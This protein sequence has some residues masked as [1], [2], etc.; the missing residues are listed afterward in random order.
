MSRRRLPE[1]A[2]G[3]RRG[4][5]HGGGSTATCLEGLRSDPDRA[6][7]E[8]YRGVVAVKCLYFDSTKSSLCPKRSR[9]SRSAPLKLSQQT[10]LPLRGL[11]SMRPS[12]E[13][14]SA[15]RW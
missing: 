7:Q 13:H 12:Q 8:G 10:L 1:S 2:D 3:A 5:E 9:P 6:G 14:Y 4:V 15:K 11:A